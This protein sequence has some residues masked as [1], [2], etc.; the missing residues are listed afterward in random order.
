MK[1]MSETM[2]LTEF[3]G[4]EKI[5]IERIYKMFALRINF[6]LDRIIEV[7][8]G[9][10]TETGLEIIMPGNAAGDDNNWFLTVDSNGDF[11]FRHKES[12]TWVRRGPK[13]KGS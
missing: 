8:T 3:K 5:A 9:G 7:T 2:Q 4:K 10:V 11:L 1:R 6:L 13:V 12:G